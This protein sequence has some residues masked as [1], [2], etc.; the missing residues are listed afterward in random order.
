MEILRI[1]KKAQ[2]V[3]ASPP[4]PESS[5]D[6]STQA[7]ASTTPPENSF[8]PEASTTPPE[9]PSSQSEDY[10]QAIGW[11]CGAVS[12]NEEGKLE[13]ALAEGYSYRLTGVPRTLRA[14][15]LQLNNAPSS[16]LWLRCY[17]NF[18]WRENAFFFIVVN[19]QPEPPEEAREGIFVLRGVWQY[20]PQSRRP[21]FTIYRNSLRFEG[22][23]IQNVHL[24]L[25]WKGETPFKFKKGGKFRPKF[26]QIEARLK[27]EKNGF[28]WVKS[29]CEPKKPPQ[30][31]QKD[32]KR[33]KKG[34]A[35]R[36]KPKALKDK[37]PATPEVPETIEVKATMAKAEVTLKFS[38]MPIARAIGNGRVAIK[39]QDEASGLVFTASLKSKTW[40]KSAQKMEE[41]ASWVGALS[42]KLGER[43]E[44]GFVL[45]DAG[46]QVFEKK[47]KAP[48]E[49]AS[50][51]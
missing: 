40:K 43:T 22:E 21:V 16:H 47:P 26:Y 19:F 45:V 6:V 48:T 33:K 12:Q 34:A 24:P 50:E 41:Y 8:Q 15:Y 37:Q 5:Q 7:E 20:L 46:V 4:A 32:I 36:P 2:P 17:P 44:G 49:P 11:L 39:L 3:E 30:R 23:K 31:L 28:E 42:G 18:N 1:Q 38:E 9:N 29:L 13:I 27:P 25:Q 14:L 51:S 10:Y 35:S